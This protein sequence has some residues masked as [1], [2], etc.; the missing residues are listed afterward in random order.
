MEQNFADMLKDAFSEVDLDFE[1]LQFDEGANAPQTKPT[2]DADIDLKDASELWTTSDQDSVQ[3]ITNVY[4]SEENE[5][6]DTDGS[7]D[8]SEELSNAFSN[9]P[10]VEAESAN[11]PPQEMNY[12]DQVTSEAQKEK[13]LCVEGMVEE[14]CM[15]SDEESDV[16]MHELVGDVAGVSEEEHDLSQEETIKLS[17]GS[18]ENQAMESEDHQLISSVLVFNENQTPEE[19][20]SGSD[21]EEPCDYN[22]G[23]QTPQ[24]D[25]EGNMDKLFIAMKPSTPVGYSDGDDL[26]EFTEED[27]EGVKES[28][29]DYPSDLFQSEGEEH[30]KSARDQPSTLTD[31]SFGNDYSTNE[32]KNLSCVE[33]DDMQQEVR[34]KDFTAADS[35]EIKELE[36]DQTISEKTDIDA[37]FQEEKADEDDPQ[38]SLTN[39]SSIEEET[40]YQGIGDERDTNNSNDQPDYDSDISSDHSTSQE[41]TSF[42]SSVRHEEEWKRDIQHDLGRADHEIDYIG[43]D[44]EDG[45]SSYLELDRDY[46]NESAILYEEYC[47]E[48]PDEQSTE[49][50]STLESAQL[51]PSIKE[52]D[53]SPSERLNSV[54]ETNTLIPE[55][56]WSLDVMMNEGNLLLDDWS[57]P[58][59]ESVGINLDEG[60]NQEGTED[61]EEL[62]SDEDVEEKERDWEQ[63][64]TRIDAFNK[65]YGDQVDTEDKSERNHKVT[66]CL[67][68]GSSEYEEDSDSD[69]EL[70]KVPDT[71]ISAVKPEYHSESDDETQEKLFL[72]E[73]PKIRPKEQQHVGPAP[74]ARPTSSKCLAGLKSVLA[75]GLVT[76]IGMVSFWWATDNLDWIH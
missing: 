37:S 73:K 39:D 72:P 61:V 23:E 64:K 20:S 47:H 10:R 54:R 41:E 32:M 42:S 26:R 59:E 15:H 52:E 58:G 22:I 68:R 74:N 76:V 56:L 33:K 71:P 49:F 63:E 9:S 11:C 1:H 70:D 35:D 44:T 21:E 66:F 19:K 57:L 69:P 30:A 34:P 28:L 6:A 27:Q 7:S 55:G 31:S 40:D 43:I 4:K 60:K 38:D 13:Q 17:F 12:D 75:L 14:E 3:T 8:S 29:A 48:E 50:C 25:S 5:D 53:Q 24:C 65:F 46:L 51:D 18:A 62:D 2:M 36:D 67:D 45:D 16:S